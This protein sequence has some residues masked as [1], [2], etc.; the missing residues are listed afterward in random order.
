MVPLPHSANLAT[1]DA[2]LRAFD[3]PSGANATVSR[4]S[5]LIRT[6][7]LNDA[8]VDREPRFLTVKVRSRAGPTVTD[9]TQRSA[10]RA[11]AEGFLAATGQGSPPAPGLAAAPPWAE[12][13]LPAV[14]QQT[15]A[16]TA[17]RFPMVHPTR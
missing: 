17:R 6:S 13:T 11:A 10:A 7:A 16:S 1:R 15:P 9:P 3:P 5:P 4:S 2:T 12:T 14:R 8:L